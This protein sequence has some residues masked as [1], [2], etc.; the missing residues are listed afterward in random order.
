M[1][2]NALKYLL[3]FGRSLRDRC[4]RWIAEWRG[5]SEEE[6]QEEYGR[7]C[8]VCR[9]RFIPRFKH[10]QLCSTCEMTYMKCWSNDCGGFFQPRNGRR[11]ETYCPECREVGKASDLA[12]NL[13]NEGYLQESPRVSNLAQPVFRLTERM[14]QNRNKLDTE[15]AEAALQRLADMDE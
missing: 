15:R 1:I 2:S 3:R 5:L 8:V 10:H 9:S 4:I 12:Q 14:I 7:P 6:I 13:V 11:S